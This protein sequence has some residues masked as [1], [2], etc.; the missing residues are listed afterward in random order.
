[1]R[2][3][4]LVHRL[5]AAAAAF[6]TGAALLVSAVP[7]LA[8]PAASADLEFRVAGESVV[9]TATK[10]LWLQLHNNGPAAATNIIV[11]ID[12]SG[13]DQ[14]QLVATLPSDEGC[15]AE[16]TKA[17][18]RV[19]GLAPGENLP[20]S[21]VVVVTSVKDG[22][23]VVDA[24]SIS[25]TVTS[26]TPD[27]NPGN[28]KKATVPLKVSPLAVDMNVAA[29]DVYSDLET[30][31]PVAPGESAPLN[32]VIANYG[33]TP[34]RGI[35]YA[36]SLPRYVTFKKTFPYCRYN[37]AKTVAACTSPDVVEPGLTVAPLDA[38]EVTVS[39]EAPGPVAL[40]D[41]IIAGGALGPAEA[42]VDPVTLDSPGDRGRTLKV[43]GSGSGD[44][45]RREADPS[46]NFARF[47]VF[48][49][50]NDND[51]SVTS[52]SGSG[53]VGATVQITV[54]VS[55]AGPAA[56]PDT[57]VKVT[58]P[59]GTVLTAV[60][61]G[62]VIEAGGRTAVCEGE[63]GAKES[64]QGVFSFKI[65]SATV[66]AD[67]KAEISGS[68]KDREP[69]NNSAAITITVTPGGGNGGGGG[70]PITGAN[71]ALIGGVGAAVVVLGVVLFLSTRRRKVMLVTP[72]ED[73]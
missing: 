18:C 49:G 2:L 52:G 5:G 27:S 64:D 31:A 37:E 33:N 60:P 38:F 45:K 56:S 19:G 23:G 32:F 68:V 34:A 7:A 4:R 15:E 6:T 47:T 30:R 8:A 39:D 14:D 65:S 53:A 73:N 10:P 62:C 58:A 35:F 9:R 48:A 46:D 25:V 42:P 40:T 55:N 50:Q 28:N 66:G 3:P 36:L 17:V 11:T 24:G 29:A 43:S 44:P 12:I 59:T 69:K 61:G 51:L 13:L 20:P 72:S 16:G 26:D 71:A 70:L 63:L 1:M 22:T 41:G 54:K 57:V 21:A 67:G